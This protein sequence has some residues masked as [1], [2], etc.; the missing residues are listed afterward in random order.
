MGLYM[1]EARP[2]GR[3]LQQVGA[4]TL[5]RSRFARGGSDGGHCFAAGASSNLL[6]LPWYVPSVCTYAAQPHWRV[7][8]VRVKT[9]RSQA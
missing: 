6:L 3:A 2:V 7:C 9:D 1:G 4:R 5:V 8:R